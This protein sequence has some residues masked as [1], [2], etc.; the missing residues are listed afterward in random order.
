MDLYQTFIGLVVYCHGIKGLSYW[1]EGLE[2]GWV[3]MFSQIS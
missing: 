3:I 2:M 1:V